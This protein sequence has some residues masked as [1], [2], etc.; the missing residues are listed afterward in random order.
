MVKGGQ[1][2]RYVGGWSSLLYVLCVYYCVLCDCKCT[3]NDVFQE[4]YC[5]FDGGSK[6]TQVFQLGELTY[7]HSI[8]G[9]AI[10]VDENRLV[11]FTPWIPHICAYV[12]VYARVCDCCNCM[13]IKLTL[14][15]LL[16]IVQHHFGGTWL[17][18]TNY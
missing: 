18:S 6:C 12:H 15:L 14:S 4:V 1:R 9:P 2:Q 16:T 8:S 13:F 3:Y 17:Y 11:S 5:Y 10:L 7:G